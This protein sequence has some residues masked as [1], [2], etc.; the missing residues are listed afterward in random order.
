MLSKKIALAFFALSVLTVSCTCPFAK[1]KK[2]EVLHPE[3]AP[4][5][6]SPEKPAAALGENPAQPW[7]ATTIES[8]VAGQPNPGKVVTVTGEVIDCSCYWQLGKHG[9]KHREC[10]Q[11][12]AR[13]G[14]PIGLLA[15]DGTVYL[16]MAE[17]HHP[18][19]DSQTT[20]REQMIEQ[21]AAI[22]TVTGTETTINKQKALF[23][24]G[25]AKK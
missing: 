1:C 5:A 19:R 10:A 8:A 18:R 25:F 4:A 2:T 23:V 9:A 14:E 3:M 13:S 16:L 22:V 11:K 7:S 24:S 6:G 15:A 12:C 21:M 20:L 17:E